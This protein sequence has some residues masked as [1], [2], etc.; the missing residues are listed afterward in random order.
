[1]KI[2]F[3]TFDREYASIKKDI[4]NAIMRVVSSSTYIL[5]KECM[6]L[7]QELARYLNSRFVVTVG[8]GTDA[9]TL[10]LMANG[11]NYG[12]EVITTSF[13]A[14]P[15]ITG[16]ERAGA[17]PV[18][19]DVIATTGLVDYSKIEQAITKKTKA[20]VPVHLYGLSV[21]MEKILAISKQY[22]LKLIEDCAQS[23]GSTRNGK[24]TGTFGHAG[25]FSF[26]PTKNLGAYG[27]GGAVCTQSESVYRKLLL[28]RNYG[29]TNRYRHDAKGLN[30][31]LDELQAAILREKLKHIAKFLNQRKKIAKYY[32]SS[33]SSVCVLNY[34]YENEHSYHLFV[35]K[36]KNREAFQSFCY[37]KGIVTLV[38]YPIPVY[39]Q[40][41]FTG[42]VSGS[43]KNA[44]ILANTVISLPL[45]PQLTTDEIEYVAKTVRTHTKY[46]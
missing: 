20:I 15:T 2:P 41:A 9:I 28:L 4:D 14:Y 30:S 46:L 22:K 35:I 12:D 19:V 42:I 21:N 18:V 39:K 23:F 24:M 45:S 34:K 26:Y 36:V 27:D 38:H 40:K 6:L 37:L 16:I 5:G 32:Y 31:R 33:L 1:M 17:V 7:E 43:C 13:T 25:A 29:Q 3:N 44:D 11:I 10:A 8:N